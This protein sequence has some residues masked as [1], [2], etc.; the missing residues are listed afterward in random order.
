MVVRSFIVSN[1][2]YDTRRPRSSQYRRRNTDGTMGY[3]IGLIVWARRAVMRMPIRATLTRAAT[4][5]MRDRGHGAFTG[6]AVD[7]HHDDAGWPSNAK[8]RAGTKQIGE[9]RP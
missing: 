8:A 7:G 3:S 9:Y 1:M 6:G 5:L 4:G 2:P